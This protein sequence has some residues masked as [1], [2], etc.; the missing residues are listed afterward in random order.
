MLLDDFRAIRP[1]AGVMHP[2]L[3]ARLGHDELK[4]RDFHP[5]QRRI[6]SSDSKLYRA[7]ETGISQAT[8][9]VIDPEPTAYLAENYFIQEQ[10]ERGVD[11]TYGDIID[12]CAISILAG[13]PL[14]YLPEKLWIRAEGQIIFPSVNLSGFAPNDLL[15]KVGGL[16]G[17]KVLAARAHAMFDVEKK[18]SVEHATADFIV[19]PLRNLVFKEILSTVRVFD[20]EHNASVE[21]LNEAADVIASSM[22]QSPWFENMRP[23]D[24]LVKEASSRDVDIIQAADM[25]AGWAGDILELQG[26]RSLASTFRRVIVNGHLL[27]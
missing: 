5:E 24:P 12:M 3:R 14:A 4:Y 6:R 16:G 23:S 25:A 11:F 2:R 20:A 7:I 26:V 27:L 9:I 8:V 18:H 10:A 1:P 15:K 22:Q 19:S 13:T 17:A 21:V